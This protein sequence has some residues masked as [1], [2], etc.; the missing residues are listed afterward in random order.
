M[1]VADATP[2]RLRGPLH[3][4]DCPDGR[5]GSAPSILSKAFAMLGAF[6][7]E[8]PTL[9]LSQVS[10]RSGLP[11]ST[12]HRI[13]QMLLELG[14]LGRNGDDYWLGP[15]MFLFG[16]RSLEFTIRDAAT[17]FMERLAAQTGHVVQLAVLRE[18]DVVYLA[19]CGQLTD[20]TPVSVGDRLPPHATAIGKALLAFST[21]PTIDAVLC[22][23]LAKLTDNTITDAS[24]LSKEL[25]RVRARRIATDDEEVQRG[26]RCIATPICTVSQLAVAAISIAFPKSATYDSGFV[27]A[28]QTMSTTISRALRR[29]EAVRH[30]ARLFW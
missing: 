19:K 7:P 12:T 16:A 18:G 28:L 17:P 1:T 14:A 15:Q 13:V 3:L 5:H 29:S 9:T 21:Q 27:P 10:M 25:N 23:E 4:E 11:K 20:L 22:R 30:D 26:L 8:H 2:S 6:D 24:V